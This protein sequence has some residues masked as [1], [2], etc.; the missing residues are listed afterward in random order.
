MA[1]QLIP[2]TQYLH[3]YHTYNGV[4]YV[5][6]NPDSN[7]CSEMACVNCAGR[8]NKEEE[9]RYLQAKKAALKV[10]LQDFVNMCQFEEKKGVVKRGVSAL[11]AVD[12]TLH[13]LTPDTR[14]RLMHS[15]AVENFIES[16]KWKFTTLMFLVQKNDIIKVLQHFCSRGWFNLNVIE[17]CDGNVCCN[18]TVSKRRDL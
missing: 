7:F 10:F 8:R 18:L 6:P 5:D 9:D 15:C 16:D 14:I 4:V 13:Y 12:D 1:N 17:D 3:W 11:S 2:E